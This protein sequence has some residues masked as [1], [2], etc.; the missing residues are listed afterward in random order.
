M[1]ASD[2]NYHDIV[3]ASAGDHQMTSK[4]IEKDLLRT[5]PNNVC[6]ARKDSTGETDQRFGGGLH[7]I[8]TRSR[9][10]LKIKFHGAES[11]TLVGVPEKG[12][13]PRSKAITWVSVLHP[14][15]HS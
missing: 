8:R 10:A 2:L 6:F 13:P 4:Q 3:K 1:D 12:R 5:L 14:F 11:S 7:P 9:V 15:A